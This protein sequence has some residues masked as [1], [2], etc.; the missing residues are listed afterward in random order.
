[1]RAEIKRL[2]AELQRTMIYVTHDQKEAMALADR[3]AVMHEAELQQ[4][5]TPSE[6]LNDPVN[7]PVRGI[8]LK[9]ASGGRRF[10]S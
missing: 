1:M 4:V 3:I 10:L 2:H 5:G 7:A 9:P 6:I 8:H